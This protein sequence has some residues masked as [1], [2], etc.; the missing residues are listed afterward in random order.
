V[1]PGSREGGVVSM[2]LDEYQ[3]AAGKTNKGTRL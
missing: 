1:V 2:T 3:A